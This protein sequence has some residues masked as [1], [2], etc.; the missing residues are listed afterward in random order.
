MSKSFEL[1]NDDGII[2][3]LLPSAIL[4]SP[5]YKHIRKEIYQNFNV[6]YIKEDVR[7][8]NV[9]I[10]VCL[11]VIRKSKNN[12]KYFYI[13]NDNY[14]LMENYLNFKQTKTLKEGS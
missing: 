12:G 4:T 7:F 8:P 2:A 1:L 11:L 13:N 14:F 5:T 9:A 10:K 3:Y 6:E